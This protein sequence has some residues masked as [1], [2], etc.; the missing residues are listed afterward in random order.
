[1]TTTEILNEL[2]ELVVKLTTTHTSTKPTKKSKREAR[3]LATKIKKLAA[4]FKSQ[5]TL[6]DKA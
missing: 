3:G 2:T 5:S 4:D 6:E 1:M